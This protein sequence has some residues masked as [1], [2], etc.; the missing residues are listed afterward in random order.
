M[1]IV[2]SPGDN[3]I[4]QLAQNQSQQSH[5]IFGNTHVMGTNQIPPLGLNEHLFILG[6][7]IKK[8]D[9]NLPEIGDEN[10]AFALDGDELF[11][12]LRSVFPAGYAADVY[13]DACQS[14][15]IP[16]GDFSFVEL[17]KTRITN[18]FEG[19]RVFGRVGDI[20]GNT[21]HPGDTQWRQA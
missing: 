15:N 8:G 6:H 3:N 13:I 11:D 7:G 9:S 20:C 14:A 16:R 10:G 21:P 1:I 18:V 19:V 5:N 2:A 17:F 4:I 12:N